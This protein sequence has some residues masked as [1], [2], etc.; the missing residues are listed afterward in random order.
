MWRLDARQERGEV[1]ISESGLRLLYLERMHIRCIYDRLRA[2]ILTC[3]NVCQVMPCILFES[4]RI[5][6]P[7]SVWG[8]PNEPYDKPACATFRPIMVAWCRAV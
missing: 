6:I 3:I 8:F 4:Y 5:S 7:Y 1:Q 2:L